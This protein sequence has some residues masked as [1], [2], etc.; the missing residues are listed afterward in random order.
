M[1]VNGLQVYKSWRHNVSFFSQFLFFIFFF[2]GG[3]GVMFGPQFALEYLWS[4]L[5][6]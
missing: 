1:S 3:G 2:G 5:L 6:V 4:L